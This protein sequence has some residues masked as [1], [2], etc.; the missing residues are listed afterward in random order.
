MYLII[1]LTA[2]K[3]LC[4][5]DHGDQGFLQFEIII[6]IFVSSFPFEYLCRGSTA[7]INNFT[8]K[9]GDRLQT[10]EF[11]VYRRQ[12]LMPEVDPRT[13]NIKR[14]FVLLLCSTGDSMSYFYATPHTTIPGHDLKTFS[15]VTPN[16]CARHCMEENAF[17]C[18]SFDY[19]VSH[20]Q[21]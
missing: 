5:N 3:Y 13:V 9:C 12:I 17:V 7:I 15:K 19:H 21:I 20:Q 14:L 1:T 18:R 11:D 8:L 4:I 6:N 16:R 2:L 10:S